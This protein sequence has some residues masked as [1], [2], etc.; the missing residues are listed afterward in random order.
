VQLIGG[1]DDSCFFVSPGTVDF[2]ATTLGCGAQR[3]NL[4]AVNQCDHFVRV[5]GAAASGPPFTAAAQL[6]FDLAPQTSHPIPIV[7]APQTPGDDVGQIYVTSSESP[8]ARAAG[9]TGGARNAS[10]VFDQWD[11]S[12]PKVDMLIVIDN[13]GSMAEEQKALAAN[14]DHLWNRIALAN[15]DFHIAVTSSGMTPYTSGWTQCPGGANGGE[16]GRFFP[17]DAS[18]PRILTPE[19]AGVKDALFANT[20]VGTCHW[21]ERFLDPVIAALTDPL[22]SSTKA[23]GTPWPSDGNAGFL[24]DDAR[25]ALL[26]VTDTDDDV[27]LVNPP[28]VSDSVTKLIAIKHG[29]RD[30]ISF[31]GIV[32]LS[33]CPTSE[34]PSGDARRFKQIAAQLNGHLYDV[35]NLNGFGAMLESSLG[36]LLQPLSSFPLSAHPKDPSAIVVTVNG[37]VSSDWSYDAAANRIVFAQGDVPA[38]GAHVTAKYEAACQ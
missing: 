23:P 18:R 35:C 2:G 11:Q 36:D 13:S 21:D 12:T 34:L 19:T 8:I 27:D 20:N 4:Y 28:P 7:Y 10:T 9:L 24:R 33:V 17:V 37:V 1:G 31:A 3:Q 38:P 26:A 32:P 25:L 15:A 14:L 30:L 29:A 6:P 16:A 5:T 22:V